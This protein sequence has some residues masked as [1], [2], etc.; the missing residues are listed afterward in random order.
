MVSSSPV[1]CSITLAGIDIAG[2]LADDGWNWLRHACLAHARQIEDRAKYVLFRFYQRRRACMNLRL[3]AMVV[4]TG[5]AM[6]MPAR[7]GEITSGPTDRIS[8]PFNVTGDHR[9]APQG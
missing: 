3:G 5:V 4:L 8:G 9:R 7:A 6:V 1:G 2:L